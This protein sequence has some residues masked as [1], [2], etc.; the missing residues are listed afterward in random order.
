[1]KKIIFNRWTMGFLWTA[2]ILAAGADIDLS[3]WWINAL[4]CAVFGF[5]A[6]AANKYAGRGR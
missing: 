4:G 5:V 3:L 2:G 6:L 1:M